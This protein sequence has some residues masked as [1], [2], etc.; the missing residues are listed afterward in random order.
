MTALSP[1]FVGPGGFLLGTLLF[2]VVILVIAR[3]VFAL[4]WRVVVIGAII[5]GLLWLL[6]AVGFGP[7]GLR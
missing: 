2:I 7:P 6:G 1:L 4:A 5:L 3:L